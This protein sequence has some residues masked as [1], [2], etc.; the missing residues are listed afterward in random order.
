MEN[1]Y[2]INKS[3]LST[4]LYVNLSNPIKIL[5]DMNDDKINKIIDNSTIIETL[6]VCINKTNTIL[7]INRS[8]L[9]NNNESYDEKNILNNIR[10]TMFIVS[11]YDS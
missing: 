4:G 9:L 10:Y 7:I 5:F 3:F 11:I 1:T 6:Y 8:T 2:N